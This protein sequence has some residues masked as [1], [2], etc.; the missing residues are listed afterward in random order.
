MGDDKTEEPT[1][2]KLDDARKEGSVW[3][4]KDLS[5]VIA[6]A[7][8]MGVVKASWASVEVKVTNLFSFAVD[9]IAH[10]E[11][12]NM[13]IFHMLALALTT[14]LT[15]CIPIAFATAISGGLLE[16]LQVGPLLA[17]KALMPKFEKLN[18]LSGIKNMFS[19][20]QIVELLKSMFKLGVTGYVVYG[21]VRDAMALVV[22]T[23]GGDANMT[24]TVLGELVSRVV[25][26]VT[27][28]F[29][30]FAIFDVWW[31]HKSYMKDQMMSKDDIKKE[32]KESEGDPHH[33]AHRKQMHQEIMEGAQMEAV[34]GA[35][36]V[37]T[38][39]DHVA[40]ALR[41][42]RDKDGA[43]RV[44]AKG[45]EFKAEKIKALAR[46]SDV[47][48]LRNVPLAHALLRTEV[49]Q[50][51]PEDLYDA[52]AEVLNFVYQLKTAAEAPARVS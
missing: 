29:I 39:P 27:M 13:A 51:I 26:K 8:G 40:V 24:M 46:E 43:P 20:K 41:Y 4:S 21:V 35:D 10:P 15:L 50:E 48:M 6:F 33:K 31:Q 45:M 18:P 32:Y 23:I 28:L 25:I 47:P 17:I 38:N 34:K 19:K 14:L 36:V 30:G 42:D 16:F 49:N 12:L 2:K 52:V 11:E 37:V 44:I 5:G 22:A 1:Q 7:V 3:K 9:H